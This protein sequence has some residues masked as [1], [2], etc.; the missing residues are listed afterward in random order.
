MPNAPRLRVTRASPAFP[1]QGDNSPGQN[2][3]FQA[4]TIWQ[5][6]FIHKGAPG[7]AGVVTSVPMSP[8]SVLGGGPP[9]GAGHAGPA[10][11]VKVRRTLPARLSNGTFVRDDA[12]TFPAD[13]HDARRRP[14]SAAGLR[15]TPA[16]G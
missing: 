1:C 2:Y 8:A 5:T 14:A 13:I 4:L 16:M 9:Q 3:G 12:A 6:F 11:I 10:A 15:K 7:R